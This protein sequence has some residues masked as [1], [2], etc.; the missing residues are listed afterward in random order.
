MV[1]KQRVGLTSS[2][3]PHEIPDCLQSKDDLLAVLLVPSESNYYSEKQETSIQLHGKLDEAVE[4]V[5]SEPI[6][7][8]MLGNIIL[9]TK[10]A[11]K[12]QFKHI[13]EA[14]LALQ[15][16]I[17]IMNIPMDTWDT[18]WYIRQIFK[19]KRIYM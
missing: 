14:N 12:V 5:V 11:V 8:D 13:R 7:S 3:L 4:H 19:Q 15:Q 1:W 2:C 6:T 18:Q 9:K 10:L 16:M 17:T